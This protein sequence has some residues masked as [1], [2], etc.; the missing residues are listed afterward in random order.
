MSDYFDRYIFRIVGRNL[1]SFIRKA[2]ESDLKFKDWCTYSVVF[3]LNMVFYKFGRPFRT[4]S[5]FLLK[6]YTYVIRVPGI[7]RTE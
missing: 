6:V 3:E 2:L 7:T 5:H 4:R 1:Q